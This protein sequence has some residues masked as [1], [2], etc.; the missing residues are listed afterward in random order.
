MGIS[1][2]W[3]TDKALEQ[4]CIDSDPDFVDA[5]GVLAGPAVQSLRMN[6]ALYLASRP[7]CVTSIQALLRWSSMGAEYAA[8]SDTNF[9]LPFYTFDAL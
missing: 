2:V 7:A 3:N 1:N 6:V 9:L 4:L 8:L 5:E